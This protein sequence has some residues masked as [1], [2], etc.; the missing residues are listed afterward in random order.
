MSFNS[1]DFAIFFPVVTVL[2]FL[3]PHRF[4]W[5]LLLLASCLFYATFIPVYIFI[6][7]FTI[8]VDYIAGIAL[9]R[10]A[11]TLR[12]NWLIMSII[13]NCGALFFF[14]YINFFGAN[15]NALAQFIHWNYSLSV[16]SVILP[17]GLSF[18][19]F[20]SLSY[21]IEV[22]RGR[23]A[24][25]RN[26]GRFALYVM[27]YPQLVAGP[28]E[29]PQNLLPQFTEQHRFELQRVLSGAELMVFGYFKKLVVADNLGI[30][31][32][33]VY[34]H[35][36]SFAGISIA[37]ATVF[38][39]FQIYADFSGYSDIARG[40]ARIM[41]FRLMENF[42][43][44][45]LSRSIQEFW[46]RWHISLSSWFRDYVY[47]PLG[48]SRASTYRWTFN[49]AAVF[50]TSG[51]W[52]GANWTF[53]IWGGLNGL[54]LIL[55]KM[56]TGLRQG[57]ALYQYVRN[58]IPRLLVMFQMAFT[59]TL[60]CISWVFFRAADVTSAFLLFKNLLHGW[61][62][63][64]RT[65]LLGQTATSFAWAAGSILLLLTAE[66]IIERDLHI[67][68]F[69]IPRYHVGT[70]LRLCASAAA[71]LLTVYLARSTSQQFIYFQF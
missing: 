41:G 15:F 52:H 32:D 46:T 6:L 38:F 71:L 51:L 14:K 43:R 4:R 18:H 26:F 63:S 59:F 30:I 8:T 2:Y 9:E 7:A 11:G 48:G 42:R 23:Q 68:L 13:A 27:F 65:V 16:L 5:L 22:Y 64:A 44:P 20:Q 61:S 12:R 57:T 28:I 3:T 39:A 49:I 69:N 70:V 34:N 62:L 66:Y 10:S 58:S 67:K 24:A 21:T 55:G 29:R 54:Y 33:R 37:L 60:V 17:I 45:Y 1:I 35:A 25:E 47:F 31:V 53:I 19:T 40:I 56:T 36:S 50:L